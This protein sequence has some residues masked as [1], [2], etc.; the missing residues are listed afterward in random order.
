MCYTAESGTL[1]ALKY[2]K[3]RGDEGIARQLEQELKQL[4]ILDDPKFHV[5]GF[6]HPKLL[7]F[8][9]EQPFTPREFTWGLIPHWTKSAEEAKKIWNHTLNAR[10]ET[11]FEKPAFRSSAHSKRCLIYLD[12]FYEHHHHQ[13]QTFPFRIAMRNGDPMVVAGLWDEWVD[14]KSGEILYSVSIVTTTGN[15]LMSKIHNNPKAEG[16]RMPVIL[17]KELQDQWLLP[18]TTTEDKS[19]VEALIRPMDQE[20]LE[21]H[22]VSKL[23]GKQAAAN[24]KE[25]EREVR[26]PELE[27]L[28]KGM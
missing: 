19:K 10:G 14:K 28:L 13:K 16:P 6:A 7:V 18:I 3:H 2:A 27:G 22:S 4:S 9:N 17:T 15:P 23:L 8:T 25:V 5:S 26:Y 11:L 12:A 20:F 1:A 24:T 21:A